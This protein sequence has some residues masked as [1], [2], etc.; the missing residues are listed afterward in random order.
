MVWWLIFNIKKN[1]NKDAFLHVRK[2][3][4]TFFSMVYYTGPS[5]AGGWGGPPVFGLT[6]HPISTRGADYTHH[7]TTSPP[8]FQTLRR[9]WDMKLFL[10][11]HLSWGHLLL[12]GDTIVQQY[13]DIKCVDFF[14]SIN[15]WFYWP[16]RPNK[17]TGMVI[18]ILKRWN[19]VWRDIFF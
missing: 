18:V 17:I 10:K 4:L 6:V 11:D 8:D 19:N 3:V 1:K 9:A 15:I 13:E 16:K 14:I 12:H 5:Q 2:R 7:S